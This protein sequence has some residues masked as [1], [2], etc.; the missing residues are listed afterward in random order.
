MY[1]LTLVALT[2]AFAA[3]SET[4]D[5]PQFL[6]PNGNGRT[7]AIDS[8]FEWPESG[9]A[10]LWRRDIGVG[11]GGAA[12]DGGEVFLLDREV[13]IED[14][15]IVLDL[16][17]GDELWSYPYEAPGRL[18]VPGTRSVPTVREDFVYTSGGQGQVTCFD[19]ETQE[20]AWSVDLSADYGGELPMFGWS[21]SVLVVDDVVVVAALG[22]DVGLVAFDRESGEERWTTPG[23]G[24]SHSTPTLMT[25]LGKPQILFLS[26]AQAGSGADIPM[27]TIISSF[28]PATGEQIWRTE[29]LLTSFPI[30]GP[31]RVDDSRFFVTG[32]YGSGST[33]MRIAMDG[34][35]FRFEELFHVARGSQIHIPLVH[36]EHIFLI[37]NEN[38]TDSRAGR[39]AGGLMCLNLEGKEMWR[40]KDA[41]HFGRGSA[42]LAG[43]KLL[44]Q[45]GFNG[46]LRVVSATSRGYEPIAEANVFGIDASRD[47]QM[48]APLALAGNRVVMRSQNELLCVE[49]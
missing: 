34:D 1:R 43:D 35:A 32:G 13:G 20:I 42:I 29:T 45:D 16:A 44:I 11:F 30:P 12:V 39:A 7:A 33:L 28:D 14:N 18:Q 21:N 36:D 40:T 22:Q 31:V 49:L 5:W 24:F 2:L 46:A 19:R 4:A 37:A 27:S 41:P 38:K 47:R 10:I 3:D 6:G 48:W 15:L 17:T 8:T 26:T 25:L 9:P 23:V